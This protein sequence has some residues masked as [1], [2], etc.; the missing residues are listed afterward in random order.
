M[1]TLKLL[2]QHLICLFFLLNFIYLFDYAG[3]LSLHGLSLD[4]VSGGWSLLWCS[5][6]SLQSAG[7]RGEGFIGCRTRLLGSVVV[8]RRLSCSHVGSSWTER[9]CLLLL[10]GGFLTPESPGKPSCLFLTRQLR[11]SVH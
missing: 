7:S 11:N 10:A 3:S 9:S 6:F 5:G 4:S 8:G 2:T 1:C